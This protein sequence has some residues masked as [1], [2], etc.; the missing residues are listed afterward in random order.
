ML[1]RMTLRVLPTLS[2]A[3]TSPEVRKRKRL[4]MLVPGLVAFFLYRL[5]KQVTPISDIWV[6]LVLSAVTS[7]ATAL[8]AYRIGRLQS[9]RSL[10]RQDG[11]QRLSWL[12]GWIGAVYGVQLTLMVLAL[13]KVVIQYDFLQH[14]DGPAMMATIIACTSVARDAFEI[15]HVRR[16]QENGQPV[17][18]FPDGTALRAWL[19][20]HLSQVV[21][22]LLVAVVMTVLVAIGIT[23]LVP[24]AASDLGQLVIV[25][26]VSGTLALAAYLWSKQPRRTW[27]SMLKTLKDLPRTELL[28]FWWWPGLA[29]SATYYLSLQGLFLFVVGTGLHNRVIQGLL[30]G[31]VAGGMLLYCSYLGHRRAVEDRLSQTVPS[32][33]LRCPFIFG[34][35]S[36]G[37]ASPPSTPTAVIGAGP[38]SSRSHA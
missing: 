21:G 31:S 11:I 2:Q 26:L 30:A 5:A 27:T 15:G 17:V 38:A 10:W 14:P 12:I 6:L 22:A 33:L 35:L 7:A 13:L 9:L 4:A 20:S 16:L 18:T 24:V 29:F 19:T 25:S 1:H 3:V 23:A 36:R 28:R 34:I 37:N 32:S 8:A